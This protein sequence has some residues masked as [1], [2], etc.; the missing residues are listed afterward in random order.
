MDGLAQYLDIRGLQRMHPTSFG[1]LLMFPL[2]SEI[3]S[4]IYQQLLDGLS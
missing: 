3:C 1:G 2:T 4:E